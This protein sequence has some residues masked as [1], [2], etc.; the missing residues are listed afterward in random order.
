MFTFELLKRFPRIDTLGV[1]QQVDTVTADGNVVRFALSAE[2][3]TA[4]R[5]IEQTLI[6]PEHIWSRVEDPT[7]YADEDPVG[8]GPFTLG[9][10]APNQY[11]MVKN[12]AYWQADT[13]Q[14][15]EIVYPA[16]NT[17]LDIVNGDYDWG[18]A[19]IMIDVE[20]TWVGLD[21]IIT[22][23]GTRRAA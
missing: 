12:D 21:P 5:P 16:S 11:S 6:V 20:N 1:W 2:N 10:F 18:Y 14:I 3:V 9:D 8:T 13:V 23:S 7:T 19:L 15:D 22:R 17:Q 4:V